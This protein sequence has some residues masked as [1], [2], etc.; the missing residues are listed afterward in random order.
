[1]TTER[2]THVDY[3]FSI[4]FAVPA[5]FRAGSEIIG[6]KTWFDEPATP[7]QVRVRSCQ[8]DGFSDYGFLIEPLSSAT[9]RGPIR[10]RAHGLLLCDALAD[11]DG[12]VEALDELP[13]DWNFGGLISFDRK[14]L[15]AFNTNCDV[16]ETLEW[17]RVLNA[18]S[19]QKIVEATFSLTDVGVRLERQ[20]G[21]IIVQQTAWEV[22]PE[23]GPRG[24]YHYP[25]HRFLNGARCQQKLREVLDL[26]DELR[27]ELRQ[28]G[29]PD[30]VIC[31]L[32]GTTDV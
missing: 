29:A 6:G 25:L 8:F 18:L 9:E 7:Y 14:T 27:E 13:A 10:G 24:S 1:V 16:A 11:V 26:Y 5:H 3:D 12:F 30:Q 31:R 20:E 21:D 22:P 32:G 19:S 4:F 17:R 15:T 2:V 28:R 23:W